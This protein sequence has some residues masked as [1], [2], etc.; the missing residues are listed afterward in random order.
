MNDLKFSRFMMT[1]D[2]Y[3]LDSLGVLQDKEP[4]KVVQVKDI[5]NAKESNNA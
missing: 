4:I 3:I 2:L 1:V 5:K